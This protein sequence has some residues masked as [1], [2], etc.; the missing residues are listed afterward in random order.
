MT[1]RRKSD[2]ETQRR[3]GNPFL[4]TRAEAGRQAK[5]DQDRNLLW[6]EIKP[7]TYAPW[8]ADERLP[9]S[10]AD[11][12]AMEAYLLGKSTYLREV[13]APDELADNHALDLGCGSGVLSC[14]LARHGARVTSVDI[15]K[16][17]TTLTA[18]NAALRGLKIDVVRADAEAIPFADG[19][20]DFVLSWGVLHHSNRTEQAFA[21]VSRILRPGGRGVIMV[22]HRN[23]LV[24]YLKGMYW[25]FVR[26][27]ILRGDSFADVT[28]LYAD[29]YY[30]RHFCSAELAGCLRDVGLRPTRLLATQQEEPVLPGCGGA[31]DRWLKKKLGWY[32]VAEIERPR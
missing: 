26:G 17:G 6:W 22:Y 23:S 32:L 12:E 18:R 13:F 7:M 14:Y 2:E 25:L 4:S 31:L 28:D 16:Q 3:T 11:F 24:Y 30:H 1:A 9:T 5:S 8:E 29:G 19:S 21:E 15:T 10:A 20:F 27:R